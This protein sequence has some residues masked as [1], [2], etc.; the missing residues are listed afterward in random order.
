MATAA[1]GVA[2][3]VSQPCGGFL[4]RES[5]ILLGFPLPRKIASLPVLWIA[6]TMAEGAAGENDFCKLC[7]CFRV[8]VGVLQYLFL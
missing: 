3:L 4:L 1:P 7:C 2:A 5:S 8:A 6:A